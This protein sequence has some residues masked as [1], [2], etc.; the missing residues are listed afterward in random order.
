MKPILADEFSS[1]HSA[2]SCDKVRFN[3][4][5][6][7]GWHI[8]KPYSRRYGFGIRLRHALLV[9][10]GKAIAVQYFQDL[11]Q[12]EKIE[13]MLKSWQTSTTKKS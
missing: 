4:T 11:T 2:Q 1:H 13:Q 3:D 5:I 12:D 6:Y 7:E 8:A 10:R 9:L